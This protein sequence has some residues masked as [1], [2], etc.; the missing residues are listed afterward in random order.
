MILTAAINQSTHTKNEYINRIVSN[1]LY[2]NVHAA[3]INQL[4]RIQYKTD[5]L[6]KVASRRRRKK[7]A[8]FR[9]SLKR[10]STHFQKDTEFTSPCINILIYIV[11]NYL[12]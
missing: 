12:D 2:L 10:F 5:S 9:R 1:K 11:S 4:I 7:G 6:P 3:N 8:S